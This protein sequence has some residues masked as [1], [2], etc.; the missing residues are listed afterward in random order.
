M[1]NV[2]SA[3]H[4]KY[5]IQAFGVGIGFG[6]QLVISGATVNE[7]SLIGCSRCDLDACSV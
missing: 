7:Q 5:N 3:F 1:L 4:C 2:Q 6:L